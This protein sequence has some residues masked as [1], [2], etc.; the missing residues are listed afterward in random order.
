MC[1]VVQEPWYYKK[2]AVPR[3]WTSR[4]SRSQPG[5]TVWSFPEFGVNMFNKPTLRLPSGNRGVQVELV[6]EVMRYQTRLRVDLVSKNKQ[7]GEPLRDIFS[8]IE[9]CLDLPTHTLFKDNWRVQVQ[10]TICKARATLMEEELEAEAEV[11][12][13]GGRRATEF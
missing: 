12:E 7:G 13:V 8:L 2:D 10:N 1:A 4:P 5:K 6:M 9:C 3:G 11:Q